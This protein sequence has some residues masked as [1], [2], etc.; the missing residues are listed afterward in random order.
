MRENKN[1]S[2]FYILMH[3]S[4]KLTMHR[5]GLHTGLKTGECMFILC[6]TFIQ[7]AVLY[8]LYISNCQMSK[9]SLK[10]TVTHTHT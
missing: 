9:K 6:P 5:K 1:V 4:Q 2:P 3:Y 7:L 10:P 8:F